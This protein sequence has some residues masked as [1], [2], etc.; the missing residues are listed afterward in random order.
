MLVGMGVEPALLTELALLGVFLGTVLPF[1]PAEP[2]LISGGALAAAGE[3]SLAAVLAVAV[4]GSVLCDLVTYRAGWAV[5]PPMLRR[6]ERR[7]KLSDALS[8]TQARLAEG[9]GMKLVGLRVV[10][11]GGFVVPMVCGVFRMPLR[12]FLL[13]SAVGSAAFSVRA[14]MLGFVGGW[15]AGDL[16]VGL[17][18][19]F[20]VALLLT[21]A[22]GWLTRHHAAP[23]QTKGAIVG[24]TVA[25]P[26]EDSTTDTASASA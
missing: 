3:V 24:D 25:D 26:V 17:V 22:A 23:K 13:I 12:Q 18:S 7:A 15:I 2:A 21:A 8:W 14:A 19:S 11:S 1:A 4:V 10:P 16:F 5:G 6:M 20:L 9:A